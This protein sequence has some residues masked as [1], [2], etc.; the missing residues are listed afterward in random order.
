MALD[1]LKIFGSKD[2]GG[3]VPVNVKIGLDPTINIAIKQAS[4]GLI[5]GTLLVSASIVFSSVVKNRRR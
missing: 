4:K 1:I 2:S 5:I 3:A